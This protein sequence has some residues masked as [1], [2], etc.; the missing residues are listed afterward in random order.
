MPLTFKGSDDAADA[1]ATLHA[2]LRERGVIGMLRL[3]V[4]EGH[5]QP[6]SSVDV[7]ESPHFVSWDLVFIVL[8]FQFFG[9][10]NGILFVHIL[11]V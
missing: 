10:Q 2:V 3:Y 11:S 1:I 9:P 4:L 7:L 8:F 5:N 6:A